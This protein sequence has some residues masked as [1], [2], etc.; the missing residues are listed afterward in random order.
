MIE[1][2]S[3]STPGY[4]FIAGCLTD[5]GASEGVRL[6]QARTRRRQRLGTGQLALA[7][8]DMRNREGES[9]FADSSSRRVFRRRQR[10][11]PQSRI[12]TQHGKDDE[13]PIGRSTE[14][15]RLKVAPP[16][17]GVRLVDGRGHLGA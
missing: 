12:A 11:L 17:R 3:V 10:I 7:G 13:E 16:I 6:V 2:R 4:D 1:A 9:K 14:H 5:A 8:V 15:G